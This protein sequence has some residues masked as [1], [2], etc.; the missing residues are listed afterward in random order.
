MPAAVVGCELAAFVEHN[1]PLLK[2]AVFVLT[3]SG[4]PEVPL[5]RQFLANELKVTED[6]SSKSV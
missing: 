6:S 1:A 2:S 3:E 4:Q 5:D